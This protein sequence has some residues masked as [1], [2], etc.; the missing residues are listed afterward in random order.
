M[1][2]V[3]FEGVSKSY[4]DGLR[5]VD[6]LDLGIVDGEFMVLVGPSGCG[7]TTALRMVAGLEDI[8]R[9]RR[10]HRRP[11]GQRPHAEGPRHR[12]GLPELRALP[13]PERARQ[14]RVPA[15]DREGAEERDPQPC[16][17]GGADPRPGAVS[18]AEAAFSIG[19]AAPASRDGPRDRPPARGVPHGR[20]VVEPRREAARSDARRHQE[21]PGKPGRDGD[22]RHPRPGRGDDDGRPRRG[23]AQGRAAAGRAAAGAVRPSRS[24]S[25]SP[26]SSAAPR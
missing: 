11:R 17:R 26:G 16:R 13:A 4:G 20:A 23:H 12:D 2:S 7:K 9:R 25:S 18:Q 1:A 14:H 3:T 15:E 10:A 19:R 24:T 5:A 8:T 21:D 22:L 6:G